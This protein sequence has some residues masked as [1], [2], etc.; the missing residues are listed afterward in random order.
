MKPGDGVAGD[1]WIVAVVPVLTRLAVY[2]SPPGEWRWDRDVELTG[3]SIPAV[4]EELKPRSRR[5]LI[6]FL[7][8]AG[9]GTN[10]T[11]R[12]SGAQKRTV[13]RAKRRLGLPI[14]G[15]TPPKNWKPWKKTPPEER[16]LWW[17]LDQEKRR[18]KREERKREQGNKE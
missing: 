9:Y 16:P 10:E 14:Q 3:V 6:E 18:K 5:M 11:V 12:C 1:G 2:V 4:A 8:R 7:L 13:V 15:E 17:H